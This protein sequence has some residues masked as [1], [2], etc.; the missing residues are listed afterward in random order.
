MTQYY[1][2]YDS[3]LVQQIGIDENDA[4]N[5]N[6]HTETI[7]HNLEVNGD[8]LVHLQDGPDHHTLAVTA[9]DDTL[10][11]NDTKLEINNTDVKLHDSALVVND[12]K[13]Q[14]NKIIE[15]AQATQTNS[16]GMYF[17]YDNH[18]WQIYIDEFN[19]LVFTYDDIVIQKLSHD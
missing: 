3:N 18:K 16:D 2:Y 15:I 19:D 9:D 4:T 1:Y 10:K 8:L 17:I 5:N 11:I 13:I 14:N 12:D 6:L 7:P